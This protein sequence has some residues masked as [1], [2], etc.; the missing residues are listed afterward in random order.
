MHISLESLTYMTTFFEPQCWNKHAQI[1]IDDFTSYRKYLSTVFTSK[2][3]FLQ[4]RQQFSHRFARKIGSLMFDS[5]LFQWTEV[6]IT[7]I[8][9]PPMLYIQH[10]ESSFKQ[11]GWAILFTD[12]AMLFLNAQKN[13]LNFFVLNFSGAI[14]AQVLRLCKHS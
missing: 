12:T 1:M 6:K 11:H 10:P 2:I 4:S 3:I 9:Q 13:I 8:R 14:P 7:F 5:K